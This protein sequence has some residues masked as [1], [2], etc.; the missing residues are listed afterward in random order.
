VNQLD[1]IPAGNLF[2]AAVWARSMGSGRRTRRKLIRRAHSVEQRRYLP[3]GSS[4]TSN[5]EER[6]HRTTDGP[7]SFLS[8]R[9]RWFSGGGPCGQAFL[10]LSTVC[11]GMG[12]AIKHSTPSAASPG[13][14]PP[15]SSTRRAEQPGSSAELKLSEQPRG[16]TRIGWIRDA[17]EHQV[18]EELGSWPMMT[19]E[20]R[21]SAWVAAPRKK[22][23]GLQ[24]KAATR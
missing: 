13:D 10:F 11:R 3:P 24:Q 18:G 4:P 1:G 8:G 23:D 9:L 2:R 12:P 20:G 5:V 15:A 6:I 22:R 14:H 16:N 19:A 21:Q 17:S 7:G